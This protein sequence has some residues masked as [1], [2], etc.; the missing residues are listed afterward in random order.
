MPIY[1]S[2]IR[3]LFYAVAEL[4]GC[5]ASTRSLDWP[6][7]YRRRLADRSLSELRRRTLGMML[8]GISMKR[9]DPYLAL[10]TWVNGRDLWASGMKTPTI[11]ILACEAALWLK[12]E[13]TFMDAFSIGKRL[14]SDSTCARLEFLKDTYRPGPAIREPRDIHLPL[15]LPHDAALPFVDHYAR[16]RAADAEGRFDI[17]LEYYKK[18]L[19]TLPVNHEATEFARNRDYEIRNN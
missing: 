3:S 10:D 19:R 14:F 13:E 4:V 8:A 6:A 2:K 15:A 17:A 16:A 9:T 7:W 1:P 12:E 18:A 11:A 5:V